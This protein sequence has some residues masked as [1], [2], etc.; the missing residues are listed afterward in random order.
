VYTALSHTVV[1]G[2]QLS[3][4][5]ITSSV[6][7]LRFPGAG[8]GHAA[9]ADRAPSRSSMSLKTVLRRGN[10]SAAA[11]DGDH[12]LPDDNEDGVSRALPTLLRMLAPQRQIPMHGEIHIVLIVPASLVLGHSS[13][14]PGDPGRAR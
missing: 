12:L 10:G 13:C 1:T 11:P 9:A 3:Q 5:G 7:H 4:P 14:G 2:T 8:P 6:A